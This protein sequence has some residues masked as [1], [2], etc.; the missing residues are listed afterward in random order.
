MSASINS[1]FG[2]KLVAIADT[3][4]SHRLAEASDQ[5][6]DLLKGEQFNSEAAAMTNR[7]LVCLCTLCVSAAKQGGWKSRVIT[8]LAQIASRSYLC[9]FA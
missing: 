4:R 6:V 2:V 1:G 5:E 3:S 9:G 7:T 8:P